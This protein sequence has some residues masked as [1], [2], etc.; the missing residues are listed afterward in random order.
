MRQ[1]AAG[2]RA[3]RTSRSSSARPSC[4]RS[5]CP[6]ATTRTPIC[7]SSPSR[8]RKDRYGATPALHVLERLEYELGVIK[9]MGFSA[10][11]LVVWDLVRYARAQGIRVGPGPGERGGL[12]RRV[13]PAHRRHRPDPL[14]P[15][16]RA[17]PQPGPQA[18]ARHRHGLRLA[19]PRRD[20]Q[21]RRAAVRLRTTSRRSSPSPRSRPGPRC[22]TRHACSATRTRVGDKIAKLMPPLIMGRDTPLERV[23]R[24]APEVTTTATRWPPSCASSTTPTPTPSASIDVARGLEGLRR[25]DGI[26]AA[27]VVITR[28][29][30]TEYLPIQRKPEP[31]DADRGRADRH[32]VR[33]ARR[34]GPRPAED[35]LPRPAQPRRHRD[36]ARPRRASHRRAARHRQRPARRPA[37]R[38]SSSSGATRSAC[39]SSRAG[40][41]GRLSSRS[42]A[43]DRFEDVAA[44]SRSTGPGP[45]AANMHNDYADRKNGRQAGLRTHP[46]LEEILGPTYGLMIYQ[47]QLMRVAQKLAGTSLRRP[48]TSARPPEEDPRADRR[49]E[50]TKFVDGCLAQGYG[51][52]SSARAVRHHRAVRRLLV[53][54]VAH[55]RL[56]ARRVPDRVPEGE[57]PGRVPRRAA[58]EREGE[59]GQVRGLPQ[60]VPPARASTV[61]V[62]DV[63]VS[64]ERLRR[65]GWRSASGFG[66]AQRRERAP[67]SRVGRHSFR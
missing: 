57:P 43:P 40:R 66:G 39:S 8:A 26:H 32:A 17:V 50:R 37:R 29:P 34:R 6:R 9:T 14:R 42:L 20:D 7:A 59:Q 1:H 23:P 13:L 51:A 33:D 30:L 65:D 58:H 3:R 61:L 12:V 38:S 67:R 31:G 10:Y 4:P 56:R 36:H 55:V 53:Q 22:A 63:N 27:A 62:P 54:Q 48:T 19:L 64:D 2:R 46:D 18:D 45:M 11:F 49:Q 16:V 15:A 25:Q 28:D 41:C 60:R 5:P 52:R 24:A 44:S 21:V 35:G 47:E